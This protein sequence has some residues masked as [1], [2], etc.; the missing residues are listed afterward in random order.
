[1]TSRWE[2][3]GM[4]FSRRLWVRAALISLLAV[5]AVA[6]A[7]VLRD[8]IP[9]DFS[10]RI[11][12]D[13]VDGILTILAS[14]ML[15]VTTFSLS[16]MVSAYGAATSQVTPRATRLLREDTTTQNVLATFIGAFL[17]SLL[18]IVALATGLY[19]EQGRVMLFV[20]TLGVIVLI[21][22]TLLRWIEHLSMFGR[23]DD[24]TRRVEEAAARALANWVEAPCLGGRL[25]A[26][27]ED[28]P[29]HARPL[30]DA[31]IGY[32]QHIDVGVLQAWAEA[33]D[34]EVFVRAR[35]GSYVEPTRPVAWVAGADTPDS[36]AEEAF[37]FSTARSFYQD[38]RFGLEVLAEIASRALS[39]AVNDPA[40]AIDVIGRAVRVLSRC[41]GVD[42]RPRGDVA[43]PRVHVPTL[44]VGDLFN[45]V[46]GPVARD[47]ATLV[48]VHMRLQKGLAMLARM[49]DNLRAPARRHAEL[50]L[51]RAEVALTI[52][53][54][55]AVLRGLAAAVG[56]EG[57]EAGLRGSERS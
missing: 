25:L 30:F 8:H 32:V 38:P 17:F 4:Q 51:A 11:G 13:S 49:G 39:P 57:K 21:V 55:K 41:A 19:G 44:E 56:R 24:T 40:T 26:H 33:H 42:G 29:E 20:V 1:M 2:W 22:V 14:S 28:V 36:L 45:D 52:D 9:A 10:A 34:A 43:C 31:R 50:A 5:A 46:L 37:V 35:P 18:G 3:I 54:D 7:G 48:E 23:V 47:G 12:A 16:T 6:A 15:A 53:E 27:D